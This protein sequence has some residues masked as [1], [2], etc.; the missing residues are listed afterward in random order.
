[1]VI[2][3]ATILFEKK[4]WVGLFERTDKEGYQVARHIFG[5]E[6]SDP[7]VYE[8]VLNN[9]HTLNFG[10]SKEIKVEIHR[11]NPKRLQREV[12]KEMEKAKQNMPSSSFAQDYMREELEKKKKERK[13]RTTAKKR[14]RQAEQFA[15]KQDKKKRKHK[16]K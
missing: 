5:G 9:Y 3:K 4:F 15:L 10:P 11:K 14:E 12:K 13:Q 1:M 7:E 2:V 8:F 6:P 16:G